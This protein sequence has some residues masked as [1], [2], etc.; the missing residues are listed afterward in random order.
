[1]TDL[2]AVTL[3]KQSA[4]ILT[5][6]K[7]FTVA[8][9]TSRGI[10]L[11]NDQ[12]QIVFLSSE[13]QRGPLTINTTPAVAWQSICQIGDPIVHSANQGRLSGR[14]IAIDLRHAEEWHVDL[15]FI[16]PFS[17]DQ[18]S[19]R[20]AVST[21]ED[22]FLLDIILPPPTPSQIRLEQTIHDLISALEENQS[23]SVTQL[24]GQLLGN[25]RGL[26]PE[27]DDVLIGLIFG[28]AY[29]SGG[30]QHNEWIQTVIPAA[31]ARTTLVSANLIESA[32]AGQADER[33]AAVLEAFSNPDLDLEEALR[34][35]LSWGSTSGRMALTGLL[36]AARVT[37][38]LA[39]GNRNAS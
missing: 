16:T 2:H 27:G 29:F 9:V 30:P 4:G 28:L 24:A 15:R 11:C 8:G 25:G 34:A 36:A 12:E 14:E 35:L 6:T 21:L 5:K 17:V 7:H 22:Q 3:G 37:G 31:Y 10:F 1:M 18:A 23:Q 20:Q 26:T 32:A 38:Q 13:S 39:S 19:V 33:L